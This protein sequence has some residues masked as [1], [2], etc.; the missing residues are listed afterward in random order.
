MKDYAETLQMLADK[1]GTTVE[2]LW[3]VMIKQAPL[4][5]T[6]DLAVIT[7]WIIS[8]VVAFRFVQMKTKEPEYEDYQKAEWSE[9]GACIAWI[10]IAVM[11]FFVFIIAGCGIEDIITGYFNPEYWA[12]MKLRG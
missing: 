9:E 1:F 5:S 3:K 8:F 7:G 11:G 12:L 6:I 4:S 2:H 10:M